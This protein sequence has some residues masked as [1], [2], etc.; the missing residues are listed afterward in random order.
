M[1]DNLRQWLYLLF[2][3]ILLGIDIGYTAG[4]VNFEDGLLTM[5]AIIGYI[6]MLKKTV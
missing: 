6:L 5:V 1:A 4:V 2:F 3:I